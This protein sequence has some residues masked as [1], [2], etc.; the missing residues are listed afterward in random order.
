MQVILN[1]IHVVA[2]L[3]MAVLFESSMVQSL[4]VGSPAPGLA[5]K[6]GTRARQSTT[7]NPV[8]CMWLSFGRRGAALVGIASPT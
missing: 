5:V 1:K 3:L 7:L 4:S 2:V 6:S 8:K